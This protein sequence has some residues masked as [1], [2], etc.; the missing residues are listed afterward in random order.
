MENS[1][2]T[3]NK[4]WSKSWFKLVENCFIC[5]ED[6][7]T[8][9]AITNAKLCVPVVTLSTRVNVKLFQQLKSGF[10]SAN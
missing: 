5:K 4:L 6:K 2:N 7:T 10:I 1:W 8:T 3:T 9:F